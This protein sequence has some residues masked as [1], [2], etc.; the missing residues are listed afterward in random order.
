MKASVRS[1]ANAGPILCKSPIPLAG[2]FALRDGV[3]CAAWLAL[4]SLLPACA[5][6]TRSAP[7]PAPS[8][9]ASAGPP[10]PLPSASAPRPVHAA[11]LALP[12]ALDGGANACRLVFGPMQQPW[13]GDAA[14][15]AT[16]RGVELVTH[17][18]GV[19]TITE[20]AAPALS[21]PKVAK[22]VLENT[23]EHVSSPPCAVAGAYAFCMD[24]S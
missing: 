8:A 24:A 7:A 13:I 3:R 4:F 21:G 17:R 2:L 12:V 1:H 14:L 5:Q 18:G 23:P 16:P 15:L 19:P 11:P 20:I 22:I 6:K 10:A 9:S